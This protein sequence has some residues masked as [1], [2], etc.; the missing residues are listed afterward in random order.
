M[1][2]PVFYNIRKMKLWRPNFVTSH[3][4]FCTKSSPSIGEGASEKF[5]FKPVNWINL[6][7]RFHFNVLHCKCL[8]PL[9]LRSCPWP[10]LMSLARIVNLESVVELVLKFNNRGLLL[11]FFYDVNLRSYP[12]LFLSSQSSSVSL[13]NPQGADPPPPLHV[14]TAGKNPPL[15]TGIGERYGQTISNLGHAALLRQCELSL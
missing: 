1:F 8:V 3:L 13:S 9:C 4:V 10:R 7:V 5:E 2:F 14:A 6:I 15:P 11:S 12:L